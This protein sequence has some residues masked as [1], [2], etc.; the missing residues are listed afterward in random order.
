MDSSSSEIIDFISL[1]KIE[2]H[3]HL[4]GSISRQCLHEVWLQKWERGETTLQDPLIEMPDGKFDYDLETSLDENKPHPLHRPTKRSPNRTRSSH[5][6]PQ[7]PF[8]RRRRN[9]SLR[10]PLHRRYIHLLPA[11]QLAH[12]H[13]L[14]ITIHFAEIPHPPTRTE[15]RTLLSYH[16][17]RLGHVIHV[18]DD[19]KPEIQKMGLGLEL[20]LSCNVHAKDDHGDVWRS[21]FWGVVGKRRAGGFMYRRRRSLW[22]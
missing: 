1:P 17:H 10:R 2:L 15:L 22:Q 5:P 18:P 11:F 7:I 9:R 4:S 3:A 8:P 20:C 21:S 14:K 16:P 6:S 19:L 13:N 12:T